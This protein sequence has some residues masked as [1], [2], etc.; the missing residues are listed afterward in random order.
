M[1][2]SLPVYTVSKPKG[3]QETHTWT[4][5]YRGNTE[6]SSYV[7]IPKLRY[8]AVFIHLSSTLGNI[9]HYIFGKNCKETE[10]IIFFRLD[11]NEVL[12]Y[13]DKN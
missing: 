6:S 10:Y 1:F 5:L 8:M 2:T 11:T 13:M 9:L 3:L 12:S 4:N 7:F